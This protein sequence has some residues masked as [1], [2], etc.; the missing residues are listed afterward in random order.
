[1]RRGR[2]WSRPPRAASTDDLGQYRVEEQHPPRGCAEPFF[3]SLE[4]ALGD[5]PFDGRKV[6]SPG[7]EGNPFREAKAHQ[8]PLDPLVRERD[9]RF[10]YDSVAVARDAGEPIFRLAVALRGVAAAPAVRPGADAGIGIVAPVSEIVPALLAGPG[11][12]GNFVG[13]E[14]GLR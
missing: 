3:A 8:Q 5:E 2:A 9:R 12:V 7:F 11:V 6:Q 1:M 13:G 14:P 10:L 4:Q